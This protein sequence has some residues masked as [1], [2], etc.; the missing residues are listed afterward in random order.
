MRDII[1]ILTIKNHKKYS[2]SKWRMGVPNIEFEI[3]NEMMQE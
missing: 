1:I 3:V 2:Q